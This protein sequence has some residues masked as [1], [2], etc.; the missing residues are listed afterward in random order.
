MR[1]IMLIL[2]MIFAGYMSYAMI[3]MT[4]KLVSLQTVLDV[5]ILVA[6]VV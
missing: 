4:D 6:M 3:E 5:V 2:G 1:K